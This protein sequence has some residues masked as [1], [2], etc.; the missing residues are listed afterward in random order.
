MTRQLSYWYEVMRLS[1]E[2][3]Q[4]SVTWPLPG[5]AVA[6]KPVGAAGPLGAPLRAK[7][8][9]VPMPGPFIQ[10]RPETKRPASAMLQPAAP[11]CALDVVTVKPT[12]AAAR[13]LPSLTTRK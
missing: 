1:S 13:F 11:V 4:R 12:L 3:V 5:P 6:V 2:A 7:R 10:L 9:E 8:M